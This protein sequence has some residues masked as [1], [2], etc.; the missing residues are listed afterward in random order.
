MSIKEYAQKLIDSDPL[1][2]DIADQ[3]ETVWI[4]SKYL[5]FDMVDAVCQLVVSDEDIADAER[6]L[7]RFA[8]YIKKC[9]PETAEDGGLIESPLRE[10]DAMKKALEET[11][12]AEI[13]GR[14]LLK[15]DSHL[16]IAGSVK[17]RGG[18]YE[19]L[20]HAEDL[21]L[22][23][24]M[25]TEDDN[26]ERFADDDMK[27]FFHKFTVQ[28]GSTGNL[29][30]S[31]GIMS[32]FLG[33]KVKVHMSA[34]A[35]QWKKD[36]L[37]SKGVDVIEYEDDYSAA[38]SEGRRQSDL[39]PTS[40]FVDDE[41]SVP[42]FLGYA[43]AAGRT[44]KQLD[45][46]GISVDEDHPLI[47]YVPCGVGGA[48]GGVCYG[49]KRLFGD[50]VHVFF[51]EPTLFPSVLLGMATDR[52]NEVSVND[53]GLNEMS[54]ADGLACA[55]PSGFVVRIDRNLL[56]GDFTVKDAILFD[57]MRMLKNTEDIFIEPSSCAAFTAPVN[58]LKYE[59]MKAYLEKQGLTAEKLANSAQICW[60]TGGRLVPDEIWDKYM[61]TY[62]E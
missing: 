28:V 48:P 43:V 18:I 24:G 19:V 34:D 39:D 45:S 50:N 33:F 20:K 6:R 8:P 60:A 9:F 62:M 31:I 3:K 10:I 27:E 21:A 29:G 22:E 4:N 55:S 17:A 5:P 41:Y 14:L 37:R 16:P 47:L 25:I 26:Y 46:M 44:K 40:Y 54:A 11:Y 23:H 15:M 59:G 13:P 58:L 35:R 36:M 53:F 1:F 2:K 38:V 56:S 57:Y 30:L 49:F 32:A 7:H 52:Y 12:D 51:C 61:N 42:L